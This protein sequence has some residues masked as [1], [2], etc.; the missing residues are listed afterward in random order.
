MKL[1]F[2]IRYQSSDIRI[3]SIGIDMENRAFS[4]SIN[5]VTYTVCIL[6]IE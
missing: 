6:Y 5:V 2:D 1:T 3:Q 4:T